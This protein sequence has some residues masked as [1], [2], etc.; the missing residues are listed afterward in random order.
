MATMPIVAVMHSCRKLLRI[1]V[2]ELLV[3]VLVI[4]AGLGWI[5]RAARIQREAVAA[6]TRAGGSVKYDWKWSGG[7]ANSGNG[8]GTQLGH[9][10]AKTHSV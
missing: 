8:T 10:N 6:I 7:S 9:L 5:V 4:G 2:R 3:L 1:S